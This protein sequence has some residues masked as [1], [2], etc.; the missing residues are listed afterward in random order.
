MALPDEIAQVLKLLEAKY[1]F[2]KS[3]EKGRNGYLFIA[4][5]RVLDRK[6]A[7][8]FYYWAD[9]TRE[10]IEPKSLDSIGSSSVIEVL[11]AALVGA[12]WAMFVTP[13][14]NNGDLDHFRETNQFGL[15]DAIRF[16][17]SLL[18]GV[19]ALHQKGFV[20]RDLKP[21]NLLVSDDV[22]PIIADFGSV[23]LIPEGQTDVPGSGHAVL[24]R[25]PESFSS[26]RYDRRGDLYQ[27][28]MVFFQVL[29]GK[30]PY[31]DDAYLS[32]PE[33][34]AYKAYTEAG[35]YFQRSKLVDTAIK[36]RA[37]DG[38]LLDLKSLPFFVPR[39]VKQVIRKATAVDPSDRYN[40]ASEF[41]SALTTLTHRVTDWQYEEAEP[42]A[43]DG[44]T[45]YRTVKTEM[46][47]IV[48]QNKGNGWRKIPGINPG[49]LKEQ[50]KLIEIRV[51]PK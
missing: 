37:C 8:K 46:L 33:R 16:T 7:I 24:Y 27:C 42:M 44:R 30:L 28:G 29:G 10:H 38:T 45:R 2:Q 26:G 4:R 48:E 40:T 32:D 9:G 39:N 15:R 49:A 23:G 14:Y 41:M 12:E 19:A 34:K 20:H 43:V 17:A 18:D 50:L 51:L 11:D 25:P 31:A 6:V 1:N 5:N 3:S 21:E 22:T 47:Y 35:D 36:K 13:F